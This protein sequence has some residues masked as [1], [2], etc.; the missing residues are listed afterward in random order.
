MAERIISVSL[1]TSTDRVV[2]NVVSTKPIRE[3]LEE[4]DVD[5]GVA[6]ISLDGSSLKAGDF[7][8]SLDELGIT[9]DRCIVL[10]TIKTETA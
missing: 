4:N 10:A 8:K 7:D 2:K 6:I 5:Y 9:G 1:R 3:L